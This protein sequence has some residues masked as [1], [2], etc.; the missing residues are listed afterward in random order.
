MS[1]KEQLL[2]D[3]KVAMRQKDAVSKNAIQMAR[4]AILQIEKDNRITLDD[5]GI[6]DVIAKEVKKRRIPAGLRKE[7]QTGSGRRIE[8]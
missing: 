5:D 7:W 8:G 1:L 2:E 6:I 3:M 4:A